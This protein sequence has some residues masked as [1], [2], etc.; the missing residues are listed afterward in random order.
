MSTVSVLKKFDFFRFSIHS[1]SFGY[2]T[3]KLS[4]YRSVRNLAKRV[5]FTW[6]TIIILGKNQHTLSLQ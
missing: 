1:L 4:V 2:F 3:L 5:N 6:F